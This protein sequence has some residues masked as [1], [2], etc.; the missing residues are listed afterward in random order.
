MARRFI[1]DQNGKNVTNSKGEKLFYSDSD[2][3]RKNDQ[4]VYRQH[5]SFWGGSSK[6]DKKYDPATGK[7]KK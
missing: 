4:T 1:K 6:V 3:D 5:N 7:F 2:G